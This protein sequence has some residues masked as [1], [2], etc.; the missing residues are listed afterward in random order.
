MI[1]HDDLVKKIARTNSEMK[2][3]ALQ[4]V[5]TEVE[6]QTKDINAFPFELTITK[7]NKYTEE[8]LSAYLKRHGYYNVKTISLVHEN[9]F[10]VTVGE[11]PTRRDALI[12]S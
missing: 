5:S 7:H 12:S 6:E 4:N 3:D 1:T 2:K 11:N 9:A 10:M 8:E